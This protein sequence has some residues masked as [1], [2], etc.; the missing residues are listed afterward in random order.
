MNAD[1]LADRVF[2]FCMSADYY[3]A[4]DNG[5][6]REEIKTLLVNSPETVIAYLLDYI[7]EV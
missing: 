5:L 3:S 6:S 7:E 1:V 2:D 4:Q